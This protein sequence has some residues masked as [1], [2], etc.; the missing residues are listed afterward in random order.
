MIEGNRVSSCKAFV[1]NWH[2]SR[3]ETHVQV[4]RIDEEQDCMISVDPGFNNLIAVAVP[5]HPEDR[6]ENLNGVKLYQTNF[7]R[8]GYQ[9]ESGMA[10]SRRHTNKLND[11]FRTGLD[12]VC[13]VSCSVRCFAS[14]I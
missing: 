7:S 10:D 2:V 6:A 13:A 3:D 14:F 9:Q 1:K 4:F 8:P 5:L 11:C 12:A